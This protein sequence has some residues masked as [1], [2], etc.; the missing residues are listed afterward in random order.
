MVRIKNGSAYNA[1]CSIS[2]PTGWTYIGGVRPTVI[3]GARNSFLSISC[4]G[5]TDADVVCGYTF[6]VKPAGS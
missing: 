2:L 3:P 1:T 5:N 6:N 4:F